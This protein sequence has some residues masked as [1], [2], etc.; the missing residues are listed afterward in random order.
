MSLVKTITD[1]KNNYNN[2]LHFRNNSEKF[3]CNDKTKENKNPRKSDL[4][5]VIILSMLLC[6]PY[7]WFGLV[8]INNIHPTLTLEYR[9]FFLILIYLMVFNYS[10]IV[11]NDFVVFLLLFLQ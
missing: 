1:F 3:S 6:I 4:M 5:I 10:I 7:I 2:I 11:M 9:N 8:Y